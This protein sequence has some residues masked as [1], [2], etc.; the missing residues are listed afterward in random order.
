MPS[1]LSLILKGKDGTTDLDFIYAS[2][3]LISYYIPYSCG[4]L[5]AACWY[6]QF[7]CGMPHTGNSDD[8]VAIQR[9][10]SRVQGQIDLRHRGSDRALEPR[11]EDVFRRLYCPGPA[12]ELTARLDFAPGVWQ[13]RAQA[14]V[15]LLMRVR[16]Y[17]AMGEE[18]LRAVVEGNGFGEAPGDCA[19]GAQALGAAATKAI[20]RALEEYVYKVINSDQIGLRP[21]EGKPAD[22]LLES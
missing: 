22:P 18:L 5:F 16:V 8:P 7:G 9:P 4:A 1:K 10:R 6:R 3:S 14:N 11:A 21:D 13:A 20:E 2:Y 12:N 17:D 19:A 15:D